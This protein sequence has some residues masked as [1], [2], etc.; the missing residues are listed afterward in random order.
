MKTKQKTVKVSPLITR[1]NVKAFKD[2][3]LNYVLGLLNNIDRITEGHLCCVY[4]SFGDCQF[5][6]GK[7][8]EHYYVY[9][10]IKPNKELLNITLVRNTDGVV[11]ETNITEEVYNKLLDCLKQRNLYDSKRK[12]FKVSKPKS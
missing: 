3:D 5:Y 1:E 11:T 9:N 4:G 12:V 8:Y 2:V 7:M 6:A 10:V